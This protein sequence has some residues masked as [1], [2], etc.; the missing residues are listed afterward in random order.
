MPGIWR[1]RKQGPCLQATHSQICENMNSFNFP[2]GAQFSRCGNVKVMEDLDVSLQARY[3]QGSPAE[4]K[5]SSTSSGWI[6]WHPFYIWGKGSPDRVCSHL[7][8]KQLRRESHHSSLNGEPWALG[9]VGEAC[10]RWRE[11]QGALTHRWMKW[12]S[13]KYW[14]P[15]AMSRATCRRSSMAREEGWFCGETVMRS[16]RGGD[17]GGWISNTSFKC[18]QGGHTWTRCPPGLPALAHLGSHLA[19]L[20]K[21]RGLSFS[22]DWWINDESTSP[23]PRLSV[24]AAGAGNPEAQEP[25]MARGPFPCSLTPTFF[26]LSLHKHLNP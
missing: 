17:V 19:A 3:R 10:R 14:Q 6:F 21:Y 18:L 9:H 26:Y 23:V 12:F 24:C 25:A 1:L 8:D 7:K 20:C 13:S 5:P 22:L 16:S 2:E 11:E 15:Q 4:V